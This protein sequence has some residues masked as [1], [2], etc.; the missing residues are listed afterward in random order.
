MAIKKISGHILVENF[1]SP[2]IVKR[3]YILSLF[4]W[5]CWKRKPHF[6][7][8]YLI[9]IFGVSLEE[10]N[11]VLKPSYYS[12]IFWYGKLTFPK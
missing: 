1:H 12:N 2:D 11:S 7:A 6:T 4:G 10:E 3:A 9:K 5:S 8:E